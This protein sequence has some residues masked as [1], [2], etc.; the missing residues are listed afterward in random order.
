[1]SMS[2]ASTCRS[3]AARFAAQAERAATVDERRAYRELQ[4]LWSE[5]SVLAERF[6]R[7]Q[8]SDAKAKIYALL[9]E[10][11]TVRKKVA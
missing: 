5:M 3:A 2:N 4:R 8:D 9:G 6:D 1:M 7:E 10:V 11:E